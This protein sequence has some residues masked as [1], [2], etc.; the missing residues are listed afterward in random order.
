M[1]YSGSRKEFVW[2]VNS[3]GSR[4]KKLLAGKAKWRCTHGDAS[5]KESLRLLN[6][7]WWANGNQK[8][9]DALEGL[10]SFFPVCPLVIYFFLASHFCNLGQYWCSFKDG[11]WSRR[12]GWEKRKDKAGNILTVSCPDGAGWGTGEKKRISSAIWI[13]KAW[14]IFSMILI[15]LSLLKHRKNVVVCSGAK[16]P[17]AFSL[18]A[19]LETFPEGCL[20]SKSFSR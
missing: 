8:Y 3:S 13:E 18:R 6:V 20:Q 15:S 5:K 1:E 11:C 19:D 4:N 12:M 16:S 17:C 14:G 2:L 10:Q 7:K 9:I